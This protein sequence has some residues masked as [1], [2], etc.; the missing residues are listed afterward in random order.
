M[1]REGMSW[2]TE[3]MSVVIFDKGVEV[4]RLFVGEAMES[5]GRELIEDHIKAIESSPWISSWH[6]KLKG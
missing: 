3:G 1:T 5:I 2:E 6:P 4:M